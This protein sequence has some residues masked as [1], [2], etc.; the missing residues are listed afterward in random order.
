M[1]EE[2]IW[3]RISEFEDMMTDPGQLT[4]EEQDQYARAMSLAI[5]ME[6]AELVDSFQWKPWKQEDWVNRDNA[7]R[8][9][10]DILFFVHHL[11]RLLGIN[12]DQIN[13]KFEEVMANNVTRHILAGEDTLT[14]QYPPGSIGARITTTPRR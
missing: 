8:E 5:F 3:N 12:P 6:V 2:H 7:T 4:R 11:A 13:Q 14:K 10:V 9:I 1:I